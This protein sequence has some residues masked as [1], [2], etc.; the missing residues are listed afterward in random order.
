MSTASPVIAGPITDH[1]AQGVKHTGEPVGRVETIAGVETYIS[2][3][4]AGTPGPKKVLLYFA[5]IFSPLFINA[6]LLQDYFASHGVYRS[7]IA[8]CLDRLTGWIGFHVLGL[9]Y[10]FGDPIQNH[11]D[12]PDFDRAAW[13]TKVRGLAKEAT[14]KWTEA[15]RKIYGMLAVST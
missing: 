4:P 1:C 3:P 10:F 5:D 9:D 13:F 7:V 14:P 15:V 11:S 6:K 8:Q 2:D 12:E